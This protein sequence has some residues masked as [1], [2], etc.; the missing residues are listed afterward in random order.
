MRKNDKIE[1]FALLVLR[2][3][4]L[5]CMLWPYKQFIKRNSIVLTI[6]QS[7]TRLYFG[8]SEQY[9]LI[10]DQSGAIG[11]EWKCVI[12]NP[13]TV[14]TKIKHPRYNILNEFLPAHS[15]FTM[16]RKNSHGSLHL[17]A[18]FDTF[19][20]QIGQLLEAQ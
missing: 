11:S 13:G 12:S 7:F 15:S 10:L 2:I 8:L 6:F 19:C 18:S 20:V 14:D 1:L 4:V 9:G 3:F 5:G 17:H 16:F